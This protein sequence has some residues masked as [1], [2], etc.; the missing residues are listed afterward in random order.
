MNDSD[1]RPDAGP[2]GDLPVGKDG[3]GKAVLELTQP[4][5]SYRS[6][7]VKPKTDLTN[8]AVT[9]SVQVTVPDALYGGSPATTTPAPEGKRRSK[10][11]RK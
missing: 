7:H 2:V 5:S 4:F 1:I 9:D 11:R 6:I 8:Q 10:P 3:A